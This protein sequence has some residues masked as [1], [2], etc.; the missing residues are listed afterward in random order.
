MSNIQKLQDA[1]FTI[2]EDTPEEYKDVIEAFN[3]AEVALLTGLTGLLTS[4]NKRF[5]RAHEKN[6]DLEPPTAYLAPPPF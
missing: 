1:G 5:E 4:V 6:P 2:G 3:E